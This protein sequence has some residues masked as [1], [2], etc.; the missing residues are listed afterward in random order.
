MTVWQ[1]ASWARDC[2]QTDCT[3]DFLVRP[4]QALMNGPKAT[5]ASPPSLVT[6]GRGVLPARELTLRTTVLS[7]FYRWTV[8]TPNSMPNRLT[9]CYVTW[10]L[11]SRAM[12][13][14][15]KPCL[16]SEVHTSLRVCVRSR[17]KENDYCQK[18]VFAA[19]ETDSRRP[20]ALIMKVSCVAQ[21][22][23]VLV[24]LL[25]YFFQTAVY[26]SAHSVVVHTENWG[27]SSNYVIALQ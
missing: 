19:S 6:C 7:L 10:A 13:R 26:R 20:L 3:A 22:M 14:L 18:P 8:S 4:I 16:Y 24:C 17:T 11:D 1:S 21:C 25:S 23:Y 2:S 12:I 27:R 15:M 5:H 9:Y